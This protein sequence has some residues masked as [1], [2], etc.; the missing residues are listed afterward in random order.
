MEVVSEVTGR[1]VL[2]LCVFTM[3]ASC[4]EPPCGCPDVLDLVFQR[5]ST[6]SSYS[7]AKIEMAGNYFTNH[8]TVFAA[9]NP[10][11]E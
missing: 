9:V 2:Q 7:V 6:G 1:S 5:E 4:V 3:A 10:N 11:S 8:K